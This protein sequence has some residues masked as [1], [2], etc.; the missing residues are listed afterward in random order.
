MAGRALVLHAVPMGRLVDP[1][2]WLEHIAP[3]ECWDLLASQS[4]ARLAV[5]VD[6]RPQIFPVNIAVT[7]DRAIVFRTAEGT[8]LEALGDIPAVAL[9]VDGVGPGESS[10]WSVLVAGSARHVRDAEQVSAFEAL[11]LVPWAPGHKT[12]WVE[13]TPDTVSGRRINPPPDT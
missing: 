12:I 3:D 6:R 10:G 13:V 9:E 4:L 2:T 11:D 5:V 1:R 8:K 7:A